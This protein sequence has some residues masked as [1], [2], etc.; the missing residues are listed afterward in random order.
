LV[1][2]APR[3]TTPTLT[4]RTQGRPSE[5]T[6][7]DSRFHQDQPP[8]SVTSAGGAWRASTAWWSQTDT[9]G[10]DAELRA[11]RDFYGRL[12]ASLGGNGAKQFLFSEYCKQYKTHGFDFYFTA[13]L[14]AHPTAEARVACVSEVSRF[15]KWNGKTAISSCDLAAKRS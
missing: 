9:Q 10:E 15:R 7:F 3:L 14:A 6:K 1:P 12:Q 4:R 13:G 2:P 8:G 5:P 11:G